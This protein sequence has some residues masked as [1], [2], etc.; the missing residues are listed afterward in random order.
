MTNTAS[1][2]GREGLVGDVASQMEDAAL[3]AARP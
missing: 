2:T 1:E 3:F